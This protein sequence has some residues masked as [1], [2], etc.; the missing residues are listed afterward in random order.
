VEWGT[1]VSKVPNR[2]AQKANYLR[3]EEAEK[4]GDFTHAARGA[5]IFNRQQAL[6]THWAQD[7]H[8][9]FDPPEQVGTKQG[10]AIRWQIVGA[11]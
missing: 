2:I 6:S 9:A 8:F 10:C 5:P 7:W 3:N 1:H 11:S 4:V